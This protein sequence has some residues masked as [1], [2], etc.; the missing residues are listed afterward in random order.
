MRCIPEPVG[1]AHRNP[2]ATAETMKAVLIRHLDELE[3]LP[4]DKLRALR[5]ER[6][7]GFGVFSEDPN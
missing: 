5:N 3:Q 6:I 7:N 2:Q 4:T 1:G